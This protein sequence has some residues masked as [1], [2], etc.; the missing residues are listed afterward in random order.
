MKI[1]IKLS[2]IFGVILI[3]SISL[4]FTDLCESGNHILSLTTA[5]TNKYFK[6]NLRNRR[7]EGQGVVADVVEVSQEECYIRVKCENDVYA[8]I[9]TSFEG[10]VKDLEVGQPISFTGDC[11]D[12]EKEFYQNSSRK[13]IVITIDNPSLRY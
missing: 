10:S 12:Y 3:S 11:N 7:V 6:R 5:Q 2:I 8:D 9:S 1:F 4:A 13:Y